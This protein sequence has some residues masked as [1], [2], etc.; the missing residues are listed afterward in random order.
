MT[1]FIFYLVIAF[2]AGTG[3]GYLIDEIEHKIIRY[4]VIVCVL[5][6]VGYVGYNIAVVSVGH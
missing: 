1:N 5:A 4:L 3:V 2:L 6:L